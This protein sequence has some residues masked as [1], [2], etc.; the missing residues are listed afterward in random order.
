MG[1]GLTGEMVGGMSG[2]VGGEVTGG[3]VGAVPGTVGDNVTCVLG[4]G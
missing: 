2:G 4:N 1:G 3:R